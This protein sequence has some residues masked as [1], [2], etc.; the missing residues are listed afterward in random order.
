MR[1]YKNPVPSV[2]DEY[3]SK[4]YSILF[5]FEE[6]VTQDEAINGINELIAQNNGKIQKE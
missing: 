5:T 2:D 6:D 3:V 1:K 4:K